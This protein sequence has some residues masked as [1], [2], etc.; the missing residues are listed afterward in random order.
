MGA[1]EHFDER[2]LT[3]YFER[4]LSA[5]EMTHLSQHLERCG[6][7]MRRFASVG[8]TQASP[9]N[10]DKSEVA[11]APEA[12]GKRP[13]PALVGRYRVENVLGMGG[14]GVVYAGHDPELDRKVA[15][16][17]LRPNPRAPA[18]I[19]RAQLTREAKAMARLSH[20]NVINVFE[21]GTVDEQ[22]FIVMELIDGTTLNGWLREKPRDWREIMRV[23]LAAGDGLAAAHA[24]GLVHRDFKPDNVLIARTGRVCVTDFGL[25][26]VG[27]EATPSLDHAM[28]VDVGMTYSGTLVGTPGYMAP[29]QMRR[30][31]PDERADVFSFCAALYEALY[32]TRP[33]KGHDLDELLAAIE[34]GKL[35][36]PRQTP[37]PSLHR[38][39]IERGLSPDPARRPAS[40]AE[41]L[42]IL[43]VDP[44]ARRWRWAGATAALLAAATV[45]GGYWR[46]R[47]RTQLCKG[48]GA[49]IAAVWNDARRDSLH[50][51]FAAT[52]AQFAE[53]V[54]ATVRKS[55]DRFAAAWSAMSTDA[56][57][58]TRLRGT[59]SEQLLDRRVRC[60]DNR[61]R[62]LNAYLD[63]MAK[64]TAGMVAQAPLAVGGQDIDRCANLEILM[65]EVE[66]PHDGNSADLDRLRTSYAELLALDNIGRIREAKVAIAALADEA[67]QRGYLVIE[68]NARHLQCGILTSEG[69]YDEAVAACQKNIAIAERAHNDIA[70][71]DIWRTVA[72][73]DLMR[74]RDEEG[75]IWVDNLTA[76]SERIHRP[77]SLE[78]PAFRARMLARLGRTDEAL[79]EIKRGFELIESSDGHADNIRAATVRDQLAAALV[80]IGRPN[81]ALPVFRRNQ[82]LVESLVGRQHPF[83]IST[84]NNLADTLSRLGKYD[85][86]RLLALIVLDADRKNLGNNHPRVANKLITLAE[87]EQGSGQLLLAVQHLGEGIGILERNKIEGEV[88]AEA[89]THLGEIQIAQ[90]QP[91]AVATLERALTVAGAAKLGPLLQAPTQFAL[92]RALPIKER[93]RAVGLATNAQKAYASSQDP[94]NV[95]AKHTV[96]AWLASTGPASK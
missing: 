84:S 89:L 10:N 50:R 25:A 13:M 87:A 95:N 28:P 19:L 59:Q 36:P 63:L 18:A 46:L 54:F 23:F 39:A 83:W 26:R 37:G 41:L 69:H 45:G 35:E 68:S 9:P 14:M 72:F 5:D 71:A 73:S 8:A 4:R 93:K 64:P 79:A 29:E 12:P 44:R 7:C 58:A 96:E 49:P 78:I 40:M 62:E 60:L 91:T 22:V 24:A 86:A 90:K 11:T 33:Y 6:D 21:I 57:E 66:P 65:A 42:R 38:R 75:L 43:R 3:A 53:P 48:A 82:A 34:S 76:L 31:I 94:A 20:P 1:G 51:A 74:G 56:C 52:G 32:G 30:E 16:K 67:H 88:L 85:E 27:G 2:A 47:A 80:E 15:I 92:A 81:E 17:L 61:L 55:L 77:P 70:I